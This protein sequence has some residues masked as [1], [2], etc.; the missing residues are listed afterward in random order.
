LSGEA[1]ARGIERMEYWGIQILNGITV[2]M[3]L[4]LLAAGFTLIFGLMGVLNLSHGTLYLLAGYVAVAVV[5]HTN[6]FFLTVIAGM[7]AIGILGM[8]MHHRLLRYAS[9]HLSQ[10]LLTIGVALFLNDLAIWVW[11]GYPYVVRKPAGFQSSFPILGN[12]SFPSY[13]L[14][15]IFTGVIVAVFLWWF[16]ERSRYGAMIRAGVDDEEMARAI[17]INIRLLMTLVFGLGATLAGLAGVIGAPLIGVYPGHDLEVLTLSLVVV[18]I[19]G[20]GSLVGAFVGALIVGVADN[21]GKILLPNLSLF[22][23]FGLMAFIL[24]VRPSGLFGKQ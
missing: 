18:V 5:R 9:D 21:L 15:V 22:F 2:G 13:R 16:H 10:A 17:G 24:A 1:T 3:L 20:M 14:L 8:L 4:F 23:I 7:F 19:G 6:N 11:G 12:I